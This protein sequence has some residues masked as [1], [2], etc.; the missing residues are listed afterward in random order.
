MSVSSMVLK[1]WQFTFIGDWPEIQKSEKIPSEF[2]QISGDW[3]KLGKLGISNLA[4]MFLIKC[5]WMLQNAKVAAFTI[6]EL[7]ENQQWG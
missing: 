4:R 7:R 2:C 5:Y 1:L 3:D 6:S